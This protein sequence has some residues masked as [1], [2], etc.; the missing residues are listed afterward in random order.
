MPSRA[1]AGSI[2]F[3]VVGDYAPAPATPI[4]VVAKKHSLKLAKP[5][6]GAKPEL[7]VPTFPDSGIKF[8]GQLAADVV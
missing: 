3:H 6:F 5:F 8:S 2:H 4:R 7:S 1:A